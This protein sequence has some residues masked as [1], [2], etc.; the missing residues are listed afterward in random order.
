[1]ATDMRRDAGYDQFGNEPK[2]KSWLASCLI[3][4]LIMTV[5]GI[6]LATAIGFWIFRNFRGLVSSAADAGIRQVVDQS[7]LTPEVK[8]RL[9]AQSGRVTQAFRDGKLSQEKAFELVEKVMDSPLMISLVTSR[10][11]CRRPLDCSVSA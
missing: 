9:L 8:Q 4:C 5:I 6:L 1:M 2:K 10:H 11:Q 3:G 7:E